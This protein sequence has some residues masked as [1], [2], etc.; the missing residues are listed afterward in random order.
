MRH[1]SHILVGFQ[2]LAMVLL[3]ECDKYKMN[4]D[5]NIIRQQHLFPCLDYALCN[6]T[7]SHSPSK[8]M[9]I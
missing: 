1:I 7:N 2:C 4:E 3:Y 9:S 6:T 8:F 5:A